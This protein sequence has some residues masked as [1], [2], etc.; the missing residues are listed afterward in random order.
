M[1]RKNGPTVREIADRIGVSVATVSRVARG[2][3]QVSPEMRQRVLDA[4]EQYH[5]RPSHLG[6]ALAHRRHAALG[7]VFPGLAG[8]YYSEVIQ[9]FEA[10]A[11]RARL[12]VLILGT[13]LLR[14][15]EELAVDM[16]DR[17][18]GI[19][20]M[21]GSLPTKVLRALASHAAQVVQFAGLP[22]AGVP[23]VR[24]ESAAAVERLTLHLIRDHGYTSL[25]FAGRP[26]GS[27]DATRRWDGFRAAH[28][29]A[30]LGAPA[31]PVEVGFEQ[32][33]GV[34]AANLLL[35]RPSP[36]RA[37]V[38]ANDEMAVG[39]LVTVLG[40]GLR[41]P[42]DVAITGF[43]DTPMASITTPPLTT[44]RQPMRE[45]GAATAR[46]LQ[47]CIAG[48]CDPDL[49]LVLGTELVLRG[50]CGCISPPADPATIRTQAAT[51]ALPP[52]P[53]RPRRR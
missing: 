40:R 7:V 51:T 49:D 35:D 48:D 14:D 25:A 17:V 30:G 19:A 5:Y 26:A 21:G 29:K 42:D 11:V 27:P 53:K 44:V 28:R 36:P 24:T 39:V 6:R 4:I 32:H 31:Q 43:D 37:I 22:V 10:E 16:A 15:S 52:I 20:V 50:S 8:P 18:D 9:G 1:A 41:V 46:T 38:C 45:L 2:V 33:D 23:T 3:G 34:I 13:H 12:S 47:S